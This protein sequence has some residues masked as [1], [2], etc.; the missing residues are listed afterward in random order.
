MDNSN[1][2]MKSE[3]SAAP[4]AKES[5]AQISSAQEAEKT[6]ARLDWL[7]NVLL[8]GVLLLGAY[9][10][11]IGV[12]W[13]EGQHLH[14]DERFLTMVSTS[15]APV[16]NLGEYFDTSTSSLN[17]NNRGYGFYVYGTLPLFIV[18]Y[19]GDWL[20]QTGYDQIHLVG[21]QVSALMD[22]GTVILV[23][24]VAAR[25]F[26]DRRV[27]LLASL[28]AALSVL[29]IQLSHYYTVDTFANFFSTLALFFAV[30]LLPNG[31]T[32]PEE[33]LAARQMVDQEAKEGQ[34]VDEE[35]AAPVYP[36]DGIFAHWKTA[37]PYILFGVALGMA[38]ASKLNAAA[39]AVLLPGA[40][41]L[42]W[43]S[44][45]PEDR[46]Y[47]A[48]V[49]LRNLV[50]AA[51]VSVIV[52]RIFQPY[53]F[54]G[55]GFFG[56]KP[57]PIW[58]NSIKEQ[59]A[60]AAGDVD[61]PPALQW[62]RRPF[63]WFAFQNL[64]V[65]G[66]G[67][68]LG[69]LSWAGFLWMG[70]RM[71]QGEWRRY[72]L[73]WGW[74][75]F[76]FYWQASSW[77]PTMR[78]L[79]LVYPTL[80]IIAAW[81]VIR[82]WERG[83]AQSSKI[84]PVKVGA[85]L[86]G[87]SVL[88]MTVSYAFAFTRIYDRPMTRVAASRWI[89]Q[90]VP[91]PINLHLV[92]ADGETN[93]PVAYRS[94]NT[95]SAG[96][97][98]ALAFRP[99]QAG[100]AREVE[101]EHLVSRQADAAIKTVFA[102]ISENPDGS[103]PLG[104]ATIVDT[105][106]ADGDPRGKRFRGSFDRPVALD[107]S[108]TYYLVVLVA[109]GDQS[110]DLAGFPALTI[111]TADGEEIFQSLPEQVQPLRS[112][113]Y[114]QVPLS[115][116]KT[117]TLKEVYLN[118]VVDW[119][120]RPEPKTL[121]L[122]IL[123]ADGGKVMGSA[124]IRDPF[125][126]Q[127]DMRGEGYLFTFPEPV[128]LQEDAP[129]SL[130]IE[131]VDG[132][133]ALAIYGS[134]QANESSWDDA[135]PVG[136]DGYN[137]YDYYQGIYRSDLNFE[138]YWD[139]NADK[140]QRFLTNL[141]RADYIFI[142]SNRQWG[143]TTRVPERY[144]LTSEYYRSLLGCPEEK[145]ITWCYSVA[146]PGMFKGNL[147]FELVSVFQSDPNLGSLRFNT[148]F[149]E[150]AFTVYDHPKVL[151]FK[152]TAEYDPDQVQAIL[153]S[154]D[155]STV[156]H[157]TPRQASFPANLLLPKG[158]L[159]QQR[160]GGTWSVLFQTGSLVNAQPV[161]TVI[162]WY[163]VLSLLG[164]MMYPF[165]RL[166]LR[167]LPDRGYPF[168]RLVGML[169][170]SYPVWLLGS[171]SVPFTPWTITAVFAGLTFVNMVLALSQR[172][173]LAR[174]LRERWKY[175]L[176]VE[177]FTLAF[178]VLFLLVRLG[179]PDLWH[180]WKG[181]EKPMDFSYLNAV[182]K[183]TTFPPYDPWFAGG[184]I[185]YYYYGYVI[186]GVVVKWLGI[187]PAVAYN[188]ILPTLFSMLAMGAFSVAWNLLSASLTRQRVQP[189]AAVYDF[190]G[191]A[192]RKEPLFAGLSAAVAMVILGNL[193][194]IRMIWHGIQRLADMQVP[195]EEANLLTRISWTFQGLARLASGASLPYGPSDWY[196]IPSRVYPGEP[197]TEF[198][199]FT[200]L[201]ADLH[202]HMIALPVTVLAL[203]W[204]LSV[205]LGRWGWKGW[206]HLGVSFL[207]G[208]LAIG[209]LRPTNT[210]DWPTYL[211]LGCV[212]VVYTALRYGQLCCLRLPVLSDIRVKRV[213]IAAFGVALLV[214]LSSLLF[215][216]YSSWYGQAYN[217]IDPWEGSR[218][219]FW[220]YI[221]H[222]GL[223][224]FV[225]FSWMARETITWMASTPVSALNR[226]RPFRRLIEAGLVVLLALVIALLV[227]KVG[228]AWLVLPA[229]A[230]AGVL[231]LRPG[232]PDAKRAVL[233]MVG[234]AL[235]LTLFVEVAVL[236]GDIGRMNTVFKFYLQ[237]WTLFT[238]SAGAGLFWLLTSFQA[239][240]QP[241][242]RPVWEFALIVLVAC[243]ALFPL[244][245]GRGKIVDRMAPA[246]PHTLDGMAY[247][248]YSTQ[249][250]ADTVL[251]L[252]EDYRAI[253]WMQ[254]NVE[255]SPVIVE[256][257]QPQYHWGTRF[258]IYTGLP[259]VVGWEWHQIQ[260]RAV[261]G[262]DWVIRRV[263]QVG[264]FYSTTDRLEALDFLRQYDVEYIIVGQLERAIYPQDG[265]QKFEQLNGDLWR[266]VYRDGQTVIYQ[267][268]A[269][270]PAQAASVSSP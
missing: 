182:L 228:I 81:A 85:V 110:I 31:S 78:Y 266:E 198:P 87:L 184:Y 14:P 151:I 54:S 100:V 63:L 260:Q 246:A 237:A 186:V 249:V 120:A 188:L 95:I 243:A 152:K 244:M 56:V 48:A 45:P 24:L 167:G 67:L 155:L 255:G 143:T 105:F 35:P 262:Q 210:W 36:W 114:Y 73:L 70:W 121:R 82:L 125:N 135:L 134:K 130:R 207:L 18:R 43:L 96:Q 230:W 239:V 52:F 223:F 240:P 71:L 248:P 133:G 111:Q 158:R 265:T 195:F 61:F 236:R 113:S 183:S 10:R 99:R 126:A 42:R 175:Y 57:N 142:S 94:G 68:P 166:A 122:T 50:I 72:L 206:G 28:F 118:H 205:L 159:G 148:Q 89:Y 64:T 252:S 131:H 47:W 251:D 233:F 163:G 103:R 84:N 60:Q 194:T 1:G 76:Y 23:Y 208:G 226:L 66:L 69:I 123:R 106:T 16:E 199:A 92:T 65:W 7:W 119:E 215:Q 20:G 137:P 116:V 179:N 172:E 268:I 90:N 144:P 180:P 203:A 83:K 160:E 235:V 30:W 86:I 29:P 267:T 224:L 15:I 156:V 49:Y 77:N 58:V 27:G 127:S 227:N 53:A 140:L 234:T 169:L 44:L 264:R 189:G 74:T 115:V 162:I 79:L 25:L 51:V 19:L 132:A 216:P 149:A 204:A 91:G 214:G 80:A 102:V 250:E 261:T 154:V 153:G 145:E 212:A 232:M 174:E 128:E 171:F 270:D 197:I 221:T 259:G 141:D 97:T 138:M 254:E 192:V 245:G 170:L 107:P 11:F 6:R 176:L 209:A 34:A 157:V 124:E 40:V 13:D 55:P 217:K 168:A 147:G 75:A 26:R 196:W 150:E 165:T 213:L 112:G 193:G 41:F 21:R 8:I 108:R 247:M 109:G 256:A 98:L 46:E 220:S 88:A 187:V 229:A 117:G 3:L 178:F 177:L 269:A 211:A 5:K 242:W 129:Y 38:T 136:L 190:P 161:V 241:R 263:A 4:S 2:V 33:E 59:R 37:I 22:L 173:A 17:P 253:R 191:G 218:S 238:I 164:W 104:S 231:L 32:A 62:A 201:Y 12:D 181:G 258:T 200:F 202:A 101:F 9:F 219:P 222:W 139:D 93:Q 257:N 146:E 225:I 185:N 39:V